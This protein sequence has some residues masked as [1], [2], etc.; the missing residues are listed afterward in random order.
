MDTRRHRTV[1]GGTVNRRITRYRMNVSSTGVCIVSSFVDRNELVQM[2]GRRM[3]A[4]GMRHDVLNWRKFIH[5]PHHR[6]LLPQLPHW[7]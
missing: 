5:R 7:P 6:P 1:I 4:H 2:R 3:S